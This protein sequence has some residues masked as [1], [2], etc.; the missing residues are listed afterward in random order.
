MLA[1]LF[2]FQVFQSKKKRK[3][4][5]WEQGTL[6]QMICKG[7]SN[8]NTRF[9]GT[10]DLSVWDTQKRKETIQIEKPPGAFS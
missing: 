3:M 1:K 8:S 2:V 9:G 5:D 7:L 6:Q 10:K 4:L